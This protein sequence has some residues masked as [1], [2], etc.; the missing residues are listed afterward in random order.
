M[1]LRRANPTDTVDIWNWR[2]D[3]HTRAMSRASDIVSWENH[4][5]WFARAL[6]DKSVILY[7]VTE[8][9]LCT[10]LGVVRFDIKSAK[11]IAE[12]SINLNPEM[13]GRG[14]G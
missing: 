10:K 1:K 4:C 6:E 14:L 13:R 11:Y 2:N 9:K 7:I 12:V 8:K 3:S 5:E